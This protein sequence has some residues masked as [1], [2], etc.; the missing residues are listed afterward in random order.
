MRTPRFVQ[1][2]EQWVSQI[3]WT[4]ITGIRSTFRFNGTKFWPT[5]HPL[6]EGTVVNY[7]YCRTLYRNAGDVGFGSGFAKPIIDL[8]VAFMGIP[9]ATTEDDTKNDFLN[10][11]LHL[12]WTDE[13]QQMLRDAMR[14]S[15]TIVRIRRPDVIDPLM[16]LDEADHGVLE[17]IVPERVEIERNAANKRIIERAL[18]HHRMIV[19][20][21]GADP[22]NGLETQTEEHEVIEEITRTNYRFYDQNESREMTELAAENRWGFVPLLEVD[23][24]WDSALQGGQSDLEP[25]IPFINAFHDIVAQSLQAHRYHSTPKV[26]IKLTGAVETFIANNWPD[27]IDPATGRVRDG[28]EIGWQGREIFF[29][30]G[31]EDAGFI[32]ARSVLG[33]SISLSEFILDCI[34]IASQTPEWAFMRVDSG[35]ANSDRNAQTVPFIKKIERKRKMFERFVQELLKMILVMNDQIPVRA[36]LT[37]EVVRSDDQMILMQAFQ[38]LVMG[39]E[40]AKQSGEIS[41]ETYQRMVRTF[42]PVM[43]NPQKEQAAI[44]PPP[45]APPAPTA[46][47]PQT[48]I[49]AGGQGANN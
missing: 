17:V 34:C 28:A 16:T 44:P 10:E 14:D 29:F 49:T 47:A 11:C 40:V 20:R 13:I 30:Q 42:L 38:Q 9:V 46:P 8:P 1:V 31:E 23:N 4:V 36:K 21:Q 37:W 32:E 7:E 12:Y 41:D 19:V 6:S 48:A 39:L 33:D 5:S 18:I 45:P 35:S 43:Q 27:A 22:K 26:K 15:K 3:P 24:E 25:V 2:V